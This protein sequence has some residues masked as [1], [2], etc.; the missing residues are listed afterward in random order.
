MNI[1]YGAKKGIRTI[2][3]GLLVKVH[4][5]DAVRYEGDFNLPRARRAEPLPVLSVGYVVNHTS[6]KLILTTGYYK[7]EGK[8]AHQD[9]LVIPQGWVRQIETIDNK[10]NNNLFGGQ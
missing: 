10:E 2:K 6:E 5:F 4:W 9:I 7:E 8:T 1:K 3:P